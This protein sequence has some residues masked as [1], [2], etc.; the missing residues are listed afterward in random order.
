MSH[1]KI[2]Q[3]VESG[4]SDEFY[5]LWLGPQMV[6]SS[7]LWYEDEDIVTAQCNKIDWHLQHSGVQSG[8]RL[9]DIGCGWGALLKRAVTS[10]GVKEATGLTLSQTQ[11]DSI[12]IQ[13]LANVEVRLESWVAHMPEQVYD[14][15]TSI[16]AFEHFVRLDQTGEKRLKIY[17]TFFEFCHRALRPQ[18]GL[19]LQTIMY[20]NFDRSRANALIAD[21]IFPE[22]DLPYLDEIV[23]SCRGLFEIE[24]I[25]ND[26]MHYARTLLHWLDNLRAKRTEAIALVGA[27][28]VASYEKFLGL[29]SIGFHTGMLNLGRIA[30]RRIDFPSC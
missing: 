13:K 16:G 28:T 3:A 18:G 17:R 12:C 11:Y 8:G 6:Y 15:I 26:R 20:E 2:I 25:R 22:S 10:I 5:R 9:L 23:Q 1:P 27:E 30:M 29:S 21:T 7:A 4:A 19:S 24:I 14:G